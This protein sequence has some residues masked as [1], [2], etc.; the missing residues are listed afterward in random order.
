MA[1]LVADQVAGGATK[2]SAKAAALARFGAEPVKDVPVRD[3]P[4]KG[5]ANAPVTIVVF[6]DFQCPSCKAA[7][8]LLAAV[9]KKNDKQVRLVHKFYPLSKHLRARDAAYAAIAAMKQGKYWAMEELIFDNQEALADQ[10]LERYAAEIGLD[11]DKFRAD[12]AAADT[13]AIV[14]RDIQDGDA[15]GLTGTPFIFVNG[16]L[17]DPAHFRLDRDLERWVATEI[18]LVGSGSA[19][20]RAKAAE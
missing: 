11:L 7:M 8:P 16:R 13:K 9:Q 1:Q 20:P 3:S 10:D 4:A 5:P 6:S 12:R 17:F 15:A 14:D 18:E 19:A 2:T